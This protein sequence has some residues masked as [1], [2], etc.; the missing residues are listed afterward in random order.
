MCDDFYLGSTRRTFSGIGLRRVGHY[1]AMTLASAVFGSGLSA[2]LLVAR[3]TT[4]KMGGSGTAF[5]R[6][7]LLRAYRWC[8]SLSKADFF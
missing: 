7:S 6:H 2:L 1:A 4:P 3:Q 5:P 8:L